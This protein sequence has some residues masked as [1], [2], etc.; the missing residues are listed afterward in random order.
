MQAA[1]RHVP[2]FTALCSTFAARVPTPGGRSMECRTRTLSPGPPRCPMIT[3]PDDHRKERHLTGLHSRSARGLYVG[4]ELWSSRCRPSPF[5]MRQIGTRI[6][7]DRCV[8]WFLPARGLHVLWGLG[9][10]TT[11]HC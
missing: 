7:H 9:R 5:A 2:P 10:W 8:G 11:A 4:A 1:A 6:L 3:G